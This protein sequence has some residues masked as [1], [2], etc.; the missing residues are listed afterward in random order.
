MEIIQID[1]TNRRQTRLFLD[2]PFRIYRHT[3]Q[4]VPPLASD[5]ALVLDRRRYPFYEHSEAAFYLAM[6]GERAVGRIAAIDNRNFNEFHKSETGFFYLFECEDNREAALGLFEAACAWARGRG[7]KKMWGPKGFTALDGL[8]LLVKG[9][10]YPPAT[11]IPY[12]PPYYEQL[13]EAAGFKPFD[14]DVSGF[15]DAR[16][17]RFP[18]KIHELSARVME[19]R[20]LRIARFRTKDELRA[21]IPSLRE[22]YNN[23]L[24]ENFDQVPLTEGEMK[25]LSEQILA[26]ADPKLVKIIM[27]DNQP[28]GFLLA[29]P[30]ITAALRRTRGKLFPF[31]WI[32]LLLELKRTRTIDVNGAGILKEY[33]GLGG[34]AILF[35]EMHKS[36]MEGR[37]HYAELVQV[38]VHNSKMQL[39][40]RDLGLDFRKV[41][42]VYEKEL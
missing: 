15:L 29:Y 4:W 9:F 7:L 18:D 23:S 24:G 40:M 26:V 14:D 3:P 30:N 20:G 28:V 10:E 41:H 35:S 39:A 38:S 16:T 2:L 34:P 13:V 22:L 12:N 21:I 27:K 1:P 11:G 17:Y 31:G 25:L 32:D 37:F 19:R 8:G 36:V 42:R 33:Q 6:E 5:A